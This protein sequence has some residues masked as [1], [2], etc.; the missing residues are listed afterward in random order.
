[1]FEKAK[2]ALH[3]K[4]STFEQKLTGSQ[5]E[6]AVRL[7]KRKFLL[8]DS[9]KQYRNFV[10]D[11]VMTT[12]FDVMT[13]DNAQDALDRLQ[14]YVYDFAVISSTL[15]DMDGYE[16]ARM[17]GADFTTK[18][19]PIIMLEHE[20]FPPTPKAHNVTG[21]MSRTFNKEILL[22]HIRYCFGRVTEAWKKEEE[23]E[24]LV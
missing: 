16:L 1:M 17:I 10:R 6:E 23:E 5:E 3:Q 15:P 13:V 19:L 8:V 14:N 12:E 2:E 24:S 18:N 4:L 22:T 11:Y 7:P 21:C 20:P 9:D